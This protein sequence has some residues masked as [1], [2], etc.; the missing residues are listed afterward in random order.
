MSTHKKSFRHLEEVLDRYRKER[1]SN[2]KRR[3]FGFAALMRR[4][5]RESRE[6]PRLRSSD[7]AF[8]QEIQC[9]LREVIESNG[10]YAAH[11]EDYTALLH[12]H[13]SALDE[14]SRSL[15]FIP[16][17]LLAITGLA[18]AA[19]ILADGADSIVASDGTSVIL[20]AAALLSAV[21][22]VLALVERVQIQGWIPIYHEFRLLLER[23]ARR[24][25]RRD[26]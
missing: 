19:G 14:R 1:R 16:V 18:A 4:Y 17:M 21:M 13:Q 25:G 9:E 22:V 6:D 23:E 5:L 3:W 20:P 26:S 8:L 12:G 11:I 10:I 2:K 24:A 15:A 7:I